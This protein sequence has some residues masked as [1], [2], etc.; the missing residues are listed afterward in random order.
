M[1][2]QYRVLIG[3][4]L[5]KDETR[6]INKIISKTFTEID[7]IY[8][9]WNPNS[10]LSSLNK[11]KAHQKIKLSKE[12]ELFLI[13]T[14]KL[15]SLSE[16]KFDPTIEAIQKLWKSH[17][18]QGTIPHNEEIN[19]LSETVGWAKIHFNEGLFW[20]EHD[21]RAL[22]LGGVAKGYAIDLIVERLND[23]G[24]LDV[25]VEWGGEIRTSG[26][27]PDQRPWKIFVSNLGSADPASALALIDMDNNA[28]ASSGDYLQNW[29]VGKTTYFHIINPRTCCPL[30]AK[31]D[32]IYSA[33]VVAK[34][35][36]TAD[37]LATTAMMF[38]N[39]EEAEKWLEKL[40][41]NMPE[42]QYWVTIR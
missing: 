32:T 31:S 24:Y 14:D 4:T 6:E 22:D 1:T 42:I 3:K 15:V 36:M 12:L 35:C 2:M 10:E 21:L 27:H 20:K 7:E 5:R 39:V 26:E 16:G 18:K 13:K 33:T 17:L 30:I 37:V 23:A 29:T 40:K 25:Y 34:D 38:S 8:N 9:K 28:V 11:S 41:I 19:K